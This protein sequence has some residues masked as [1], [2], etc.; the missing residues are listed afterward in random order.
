MSFLSRLVSFFTRSAPAAA[1]VPA[2]ARVQ[3][4]RQVKA[5]SFADPKDL[6]AF[7][8]WYKI[9]RA[10]GFSHDAATNRAFKKG[11]N[12]IGFTGLDCSDP[13]ICYCALP[14]EVW[15]ARWG[16]AQNAAGRRV[17]VTYNGK[18]YPGMLG[19]TMPALFNITNGAGID[20]NPGFARALGVTP[21]FTLQVSW[22]WAE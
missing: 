12:G 10:D 19:D 8:K 20:L 15:T 17:I 9:Y 3:V 6:F 16:K 11:D 13:S 22:R 5:T 21:P 18:E 1:P 4:N 2:P 14:R 7:R